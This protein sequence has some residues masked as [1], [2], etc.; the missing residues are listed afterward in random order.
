MNNSIAFADFARVFKENLSGRSRSVKGV[1]DVSSSQKK[2]K[3]LKEGDELKAQV[4]KNTEKLIAAVWRERTLHL[5]PAR[6]RRT[7]EGWYDVVNCG[8]QHPFAYGQEQKSLREEALRLQLA[9]GKPYR[10]N[11]RYRVWS[12]TYTTLNLPPVELELAMD[13]FYRILSARIYY[14]RCGDI[15]QAE[16]LAYTDLMIDGEIHPWADGGG[17]IA[18]A[19]VMWLSALIPDWKLPLFAATRDEHYKTIIDLAGHTAYYRTAL[20][21][22]H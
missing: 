21:K 19:A 22:G 6:I 17:R 4:E 16:L 2:K 5:H 15:S 10:I 20:T 18:T 3:L 12:V 13:K 9:T 11:P 1:S 7:M 14:A 8:L